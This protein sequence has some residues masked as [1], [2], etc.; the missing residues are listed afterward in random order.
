[1][2]ISRTNT[3]LASGSRAKMIN[4]ATEFDNRNNQGNCPLN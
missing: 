2:F 4:L 1:M 3:A